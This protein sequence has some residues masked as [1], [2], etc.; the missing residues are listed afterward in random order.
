VIH[1]WPSTTSDVTVVGRPGEGAVTAP[2]RK[3]R[4]SWLGIALRTY[5]LTVIAPEFVLGLVAGGV[6]GSSVTALA[7]LFCGANR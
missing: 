1:C 3:S 6:I 7:F 5:E 2:N 4:P